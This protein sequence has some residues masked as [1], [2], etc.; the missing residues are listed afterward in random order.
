MEGR[1]NRK[2]QEDRPVRRADRHRRKKV[3]KG[4]V[5]LACVALLALLGAS[6]G[7]GWYF[8][9]ES[10]RY[11]GEIL[12]VN[13]QNPLPEDYVPEG[14]VN[15]YEMRHSFRLGPERHLFDARDLRGHGTHVCRSGG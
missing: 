1:K 15:L 9:V 5:I 4:K 6:F 8:G 12:L 3:S 10:T 7:A 11:K 13:E 2:V 14:L